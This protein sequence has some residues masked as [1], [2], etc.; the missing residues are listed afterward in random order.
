[1][2][3]DVCNHVHVDCPRSQLSLH[4]LFDRAIDPLKFS[5]WYLASTIHQGF[6]EALMTL[7]HLVM[8]AEGYPKIKVFGNPLLRKLVV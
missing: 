6:L 4:R 8:V 2:H 5:R 7:C 3:P 1:M